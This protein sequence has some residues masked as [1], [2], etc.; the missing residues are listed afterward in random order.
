M[1]PRVFLDVDPRSLR[2]PLT[3]QTGADPF[4]VALQTSRYGSSVAGMPPI[5]VASGRAPG[6]MDSHQSE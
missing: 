4:T 2:L 1:N 3:R 6:R 5:L